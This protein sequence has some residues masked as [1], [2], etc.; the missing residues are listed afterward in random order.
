MD[1]NRCE[2]EML[3]RVPGIGVKSALRIRL[4]RRTAR[5][6]LEDLKKPVSYTHLDVYKRQVSHCILN[7]AAKVVLY[8]EAEIKAEEALRR[9]FVGRALEL[10]VQLVQLPCP[11]FTLYGAQRWGLSLI[12]I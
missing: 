3:L 6:R 1:V 9:R 11:E 2:Y 12:H 5:L 7:T 10:G 8:D 4:A